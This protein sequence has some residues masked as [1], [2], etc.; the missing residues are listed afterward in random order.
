MTT[1]IS[2]FPSTNYVSNR[3]AAVGAILSGYRLQLSQVLQKGLVHQNNSVS[4]KFQQES[5]RV[6]TK[7]G[8]TGTYYEHT[9]LILYFTYTPRCRSLLNTFIY[10]QSHSTGSNSC[11]MHAISR[12]RTLKR[13]LDWTNKVTLCRLS[14]SAVGEAPEKY[15]TSQ[16]KPARSR[17]C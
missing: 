6:L 3:N 10:R 4:V 17:F 9:K 13:R 8:I 14:Q 5:V 7:L 16:K 12:V 15:A 2:F 1:T 11:F